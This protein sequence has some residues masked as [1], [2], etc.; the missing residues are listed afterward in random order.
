MTIRFKIE[1]D[2]AFVC[3]DESNGMT[4]Y[5]YPTSP[6]A[7]TAARLADHPDKLLRFAA[8]RL[9]EEHGGLPRGNPWTVE[10]DARNWV[11]L[12]ATQMQEA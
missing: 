1:A 3:G 12:R 11:K 6:N 10:Y 4:S 8:K 5:S 9:R 2:G 7:R